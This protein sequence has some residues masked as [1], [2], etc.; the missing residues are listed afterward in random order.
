MLTEPQRQTLLELHAKGMGIR[1]IAR[2]LHH[3]RH[4]VRRVLSEG[5]QPPPRPETSAPPALSSRLPE[6][7]CKAQENV[8]RLQALLREQE[9][10][11]V[12][13]S[14]LTYWVR[15]AQ[16]REPLPQRTGHYTFA[17]GEEMQQDTSPHRL[18]IGGTTL[19][20]QCAGLV[21]AFSHYA[22]VQYYPAFTRF[23]A[24]VFL[25]AGFG[26]FGGAAR[27][28]LIDNTS[29][30]VA[31]GSG[32]D[33]LIAAPMAR[34]GECFGVR[35][36]PHAIGHADRK[37]QVERLFHYV[38]HNFLPGRTFADWHDLNAQARHWCEQVANQKV[39]R[40]LGTAP[41]AAFEQERPFLQPL[42][43]HCPPVCVIVP[44]VVDTEGYV[45]LQTN[46]YSVPE[47]L[48]GKQVDVY[49]YFEEVVVCFAGKIVARHPRA[50]GQRER[51]L[52]AAGHHRPL[53]GRERRR[54]PSPQQ[55]A[56]L[57]D[58]P[59]PLT[60]YV[61]ALVAHAPGRGAARL[62]R[63]LQLKRTYPTEPFLGAIAQAL[64]YG[65][66]DIGRLEALILKQVRG[67]FFLIQEGDAD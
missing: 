2:T 63:L 49:Q 43:A 5:S 11:E 59:P 60:Q 17:P 40:S 7:F 19:T 37:A 31:A 41:R 67:E 1:Q 65:L 30:L 39:K 34:F 58:A 64:A 62:K 38:E 9:G 44:R 20:A 28:C 8:V 57:Q 42:P 18:V 29:V 10:L 15:Q 45:H 50:I 46:R 51:R 25:N 16:L 36:V 47:R 14:T 26:F 48:L 3:S 52:T 12:P 66:Y 32:P 55:Q 35:F 21:L 54:E 22:F 56:L 33:A 6:L 27:R 24:Q 4:T 53:G 61:E 23:E 13:Y